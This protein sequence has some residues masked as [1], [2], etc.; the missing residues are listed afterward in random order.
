MSIWRLSWTKIRDAILAC[1]VTRDT[2]FFRARR[3]GT[4]CPSNQARRRLTTRPRILVAGVGNIFLGDDGFGSEAARRL[5]E[6]PL[7][8]EVRV[9]DFGI[10]SIDL[11]YALMDGYETTILL[12][13]TPQGGY[14]P[15]WRDGTT[16]VDR[17]AP[18]NTQVTEQRTPPKRTF[19]TER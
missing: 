2:A 18:G 10:R 9:V 7:P 1:D 13:A 8:D 4:A 15:G 14:L 5:Q 17:A 16:R 19:G 11:A 12:D 3:S 6:R